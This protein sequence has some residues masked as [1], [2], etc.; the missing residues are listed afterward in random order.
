MKKKMALA[1]GGVALV[2]TLAIGG[3]LAYFT[4]TDA[5]DRKSVV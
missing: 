1:L 4:D 2:A 3:T 5:A